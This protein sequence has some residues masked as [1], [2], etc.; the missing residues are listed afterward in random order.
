[1]IFINE[2]LR[3]IGSFP[4][5]QRSIDVLD[6]C[7]LPAEVHIFTSSHGIQPCTSLLL[8][9]LVYALYILTNNY[10][11]FLGKICYL[12]EF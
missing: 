11:T 5:C 7:C 8:M 12:V 6:S 2:L 4:T 3:Q 1:M 9:Y 10:T